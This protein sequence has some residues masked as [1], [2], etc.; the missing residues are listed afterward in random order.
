MK[1][2]KIIIE[3]AILSCVV[4]TLAWAASVIR[5]DSSQTNSFAPNAVISTYQPYCNASGVVVGNYIP[6]ETYYA[7]TASGVSVVTTLDGAS[8][9]SGTHVFTSARTYSGAN[10]I[11]IGCPVLQ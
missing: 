7:Y 8:G 11:S 5:A 1:Y 10:L 9:V 6:A 4:I 2:L 3:A